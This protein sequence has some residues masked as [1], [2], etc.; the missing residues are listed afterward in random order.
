[1]SQKNIPVDPAVNFGKNS[2]L[3]TFAG[4]ASHLSSNCVRFGRELA[5][6]GE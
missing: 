2:E 3:S 5:L 6:A 4:R 1:M